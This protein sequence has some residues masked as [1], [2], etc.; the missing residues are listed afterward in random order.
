MEEGK[1]KGS[2]T[3]NRNTTENVKSSKK[4]AN[5][6][7]TLQEEEKDDLKCKKTEEIESAQEIDIT[8]ATKTENRRQCGI[9]NTVI[10][11]IEECIE[12]V[13]T[14]IEEK[15]KTEK[16]ESSSN[17]EEC[18]AKDKEMSDEGSLSWTREEELL[19]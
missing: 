10:E 18:S 14:R 19:H 12:V 5:K 2:T 9:D 11:D 3:R 7:I 1:K 4:Q 15:H 6:F 8:E 13:S 17:K 16:E